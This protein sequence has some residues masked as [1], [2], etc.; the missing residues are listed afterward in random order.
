MK[1]L[2]IKIKLIV[3]TGPLVA[4][5][6]IAS[7]FYSS[8][9]R[10]VLSETETMF[11]DNLYTISSELINS[12]RDLY[13]AFTAALEY[14]NDSDNLDSAAAQELLDEYTENTQ[15]VIDNVEGAAKLAQNNKDLWSGIKAEDGRTFEELYNGYDEALT[16]WEATYD[17]ASK[18][19]NFSAYEEKFH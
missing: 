18:A 7:L 4:A 19:G 11:Y 1:N 5:L 6:I 13:Q 2:S 10:N 16:E 17:L 12:D 15:Q 9:M 3:L 14:R 8:E